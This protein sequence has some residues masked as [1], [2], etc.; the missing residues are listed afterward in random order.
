M[1]YLKEKGNVDIIGVANWNYNRVKA[2]NDYAQKHG[3]IPFKTV[4]TW[5]SLAEYKYE[6]WADENT[7]HMDDQ[8]YEYMR[9]SNMFGMAYTSQCKGFFQKAVKY[10]LENVDEFLKHRIVTERNLKKLDYIK[11]YCNEY[12]VSATAFV[13]SYIT[14]N[15]LEG[16]ALVSCTNIMQLKE[17]LN[18]CNFAL[19]EKIISEIISI[20]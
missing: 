4:Q 13:N 2:A 11:S 8:M 6:M 18:E 20:I 16:V 5:W 7:T 3:M 10:G 19:D 14:S 12:N 9:N 15:R 1:Q 17:I